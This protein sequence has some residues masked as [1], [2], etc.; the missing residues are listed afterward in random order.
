MRQASRVLSEIADV[1]TSEG[2]TGLSVHDLRKIADALSIPRMTDDARDAR[3][4][5]QKVYQTLAMT[6]VRPLEKIAAWSG[7]RKDA[8]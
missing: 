1:A 4:F 8:A 7:L 3:T 5:G 2:K 6:P